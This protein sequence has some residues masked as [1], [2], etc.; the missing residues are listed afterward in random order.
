MGPKYSWGR[1]AGTKTYQIKGL[2]PA[3]GDSFPLYIW[4]D[5]TTMPFNHALDRKQMHAMVK[6]GYVA[7]Q[8]DYYKYSYG[9]GW[10]GCSQYE[11][12]A[13]S[14]FKGPESALAKLC[15][16]PRVDCSKGIAVHGFSQ[17][18][19][20]AILGAKYSPQVKA[21]LSYG[22]G[23]RTFGTSSYCMKDRYVS[24]YLPRSQRRYVAGSRDPI[25]GGLFSKYGTIRQHRQ[26]T[27]YK[28]GWSRFNCIQP[29]GSG[30]YLVSRS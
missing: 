7:V 1:S 21:A 28:C 20:I 2:E 5:G 22:N 9:S 11:A 4:L 3:E 14:I 12:K 30:Y 18:S 27:G 19:H 6:R 16:R 15:A 26:L 17:G 23:V 29:D 8:V 10:L 24:K 25:F 13:R